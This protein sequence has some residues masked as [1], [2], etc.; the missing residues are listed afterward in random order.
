MKDPRMEK[1][2]QSIINYAIKLKPGEK[3]LIEVNGLEIP[4]AQALV[5]YAYEAGGHPFLHVNNNTLLRELLKGM[6]EEQ[7]Q[8]MARWDL[9][10]MKEMDA[11]VGIRAGENANELSDVPGDKM[12]IY[13]KE[14]QRT[15]TDHRVSHTKWVVMRYPNASTAQ[16]A[17][18]SIE[19]FEDFYFNVCNLDYAKM[20]KAMDPLVELIERTD[21]VRITGPGTDL[22]FSIK[23]MKGIKC[24]G[25]INIPDGEVYTAPLR[26]SVNGRISY[27]IAALYQGFTY[28]NIVLEFKDGK[29]VKA[30]A[31]DTERIEEI[32][33]TD[34][35][36]RYIGE[37]AIGV[38]PYILHPMKDTL[39]DEKIDGSFHFTP[40]NCYDDCYNGNKSAIHWDLVCIQRP[41]YGGGE[42]YFDDVL[43]RKDG[44][45]VIPEL[46]GLNPENLK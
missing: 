12:S 9:A 6:T 3:V 17:N 42:M 2:A 16:L 8:A 35:G 11:F 22:T 15:V 36:A 18:T 30:T 31:N 14:Y 32:F 10:R 29:I 34:E 7:A 40:G 46:Q 44:R 24:D 33:N 27:T 45:F 39:F 23:G 4:L 5:K 41:E 37:F 13:Q 25:H 26:E 19:A 28:E 38:N 20:S 1:L 21:K 43:I